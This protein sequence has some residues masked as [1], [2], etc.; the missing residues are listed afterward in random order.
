MSLN[1]AIKANPECVFNG[2]LCL[3]FIITFASV[4]TK[5]I[6]RITHPGRLPFR[7]IL[8]LQLTNPNDP[9]MTTIMR[10]QLPL[11]LLPT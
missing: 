9:R 1:G 3:S 7:R 8:I 4:K 6:I 2:S 10:N 11:V 5:F